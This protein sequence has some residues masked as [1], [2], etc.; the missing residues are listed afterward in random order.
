M[1]KLITILLIVYATNA[2]S[3]NKSNSAPAPTAAPAASPA[4]APTTAQPTAT[5]ASAASPS[6]S[7]ALTSVFNNQSSF[8]LLS[9][10]KVQSIPSQ[11][12]SNSKSPMIAE[13]TLVPIH[14]TTFEDIYIG[15]CGALAPVFSTTSTQLYAAIAG[16]KNMTKFQVLYNIP[17]I[18]QTFNPMLNDLSNGLNTNKV[19][20]GNIPDKTIKYGPEA[21]LYLT[22]ADINSYLSALQATSTAANNISQTLTNLANIVTNNILESIHY[23]REKKSIILQPSIVAS[24]ENLMNQIEAGNSAM[25]SGFKSIITTGMSLLN[26]QTGECAQNFL[27]ILM[28]WLN[29][30][31][32][33]LNYLNPQLSSLAAGFLKDGKPDNATGTVTV[34]ISK[35]NYQIES[36]LYEIAH[37]IRILGD[38]FELFTQSLQYMRKTQKC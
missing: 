7:Q 14:V 23:T 36:A 10:S 28:T 11:M 25:E 38:Y 32:A 21:Y 37:F 4:Q 12:T 19:N 24:I 33:D 27:G 1:L 3:I 34:K 8:P 9:S 15:F 13:S 22:P 20:I 2:S 18:I 16:M 30:V 5:A 26:F 6:G 35:I 29:E 17:T 31:V